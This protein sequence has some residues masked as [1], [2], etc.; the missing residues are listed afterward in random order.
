MKCR[1]GGGES[2]AARGERR[3]ARGERREITR[4]IGSCRNEFIRDTRG[5]RSRRGLDASGRWRRRVLDWLGDR[6]DATATESRWGEIS[7]K[8]RRWRGCNVEE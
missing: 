4:R 8:R 2:R 6:V 5:E 3:E 1:R 7:R